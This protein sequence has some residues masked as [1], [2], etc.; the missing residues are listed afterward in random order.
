MEKNS[1]ML[2]FN[3]SDDQFIVFLDS[4][5]KSHKENLIHKLNDY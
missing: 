5:S 1:T 3:S 2:L 4:N